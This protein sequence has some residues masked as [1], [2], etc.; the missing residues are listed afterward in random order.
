LTGE[1]L[2]VRKDDDPKTLETRLDN[3]HKETDPVL[4]YYRKKGV[5]KGVNADQAI[6][7]VWTDLKAAI[8]GDA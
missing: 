7:K 4:D 6:Q 8:G 2:E 5:F 3:Y 1:P